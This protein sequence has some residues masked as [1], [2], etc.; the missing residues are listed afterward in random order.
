[1]GCEQVVIYRFIQEKKHSE[2]SECLFRTVNN[3][4]KDKKYYLRIFIRMLLKET[5]LP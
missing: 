3:E 1:M 2:E 5:S 4:K